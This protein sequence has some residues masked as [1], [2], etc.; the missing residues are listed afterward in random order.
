ML[1]FGDEYIA[2]SIASDVGTIL[3][4][5]TSGVPYQFDTNTD[6]L[7]ELSTAEHDGWLY[8]GCPGYTMRRLKYNPA[9]TNTLTI[10]AP[11][12]TRGS[13]F[14]GTDIIKDKWL[15]TTVDY[16]PTIVAAWRGRL[17]VSGNSKRPTAVAS[18]NLKFSNSGAIAYGDLES[19]TDP[20][21]R[22]SSNVVQTVTVVT[23]RC[24][25]D[26]DLS[27]A[28]GQTKWLIA[29]KILMQGTTKQEIALQ[30]SVEGRINPNIYTQPLVRH[31]IHGHNGSTSRIALPHT[32]GVIHINGDEVKILT[33]ST[34]KQAYVSTSLSLHA[35][36][37]GPFR[38]AGMSTKPW[39]IFWF[40]TT[41]GKIWTL[42]Y[43][44]KNQVYAWSE[45]YTLNSDGTHARY[46][47]MCT[48]RTDTE[49]Q[50]YFLVE[51]DT[52]VY[53]ERMRAID[54]SEQAI[55]ARLDCAITSTNPTPTTITV[56]AS[57]LTG[58]SK[59]YSLG[60]MVNG[61]LEQSQTASASVS[62]ISATTVTVGI[63]FPSII[64]T[65]V[66]RRVAEDDS[67]VGRNA[68]AVETNLIVHRTMGIKVG[69][70][71]G[72]IYS[73]QGRDW[74]TPLG[75]SQEWASGE[76]AVTLD[77]NY[78][79]TRVCVQSTGALPFEIIGI[80]TTMKIGGQ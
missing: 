38:Q 70:E 50:V 68:R 72:Q 3:A 44:P 12:T 36:V 69:L 4:S 32:D 16:A 52:G 9:P 64:K 31:E 43:E 55:S 62:L 60:I 57:P 22:D 7:S 34:E 54:P 51:R 15:N 77:G 11:L 58:N 45:H 5:V 41:D 66:L 42:S 8:I 28:S 26:Y 76:L 80:K 25:F 6:D 47:S 2:I 56:D 23:E 40:I 35:N 67:T 49:E 14:A 46:L 24:A 75:Q 29:G 61:G 74:S 63:E 19:Y 21:L 65:C 1:M 37:K 53:L 17:I 48:M 27:T 73:V 30:E 78:E 33:Y 39:T 10:E 18:P 59:A 20:Y 13:G 71:S 79:P